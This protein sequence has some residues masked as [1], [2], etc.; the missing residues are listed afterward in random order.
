MDF[1]RIAKALVV[2]FE[3]IGAP[4]IHVRYDGNELLCNHKSIAGCIA[5]LLDSLGYVGITGYYD[6]SD[7]CDH[8]GYAGCYYVTVD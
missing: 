6:P 2:F 5:D 8:G 4:N 7:D 1:D 3:N